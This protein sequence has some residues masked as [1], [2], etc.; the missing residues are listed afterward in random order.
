MW[1]H[2]LFCSRQRE[3]FVKR[4]METN[5]QTQENNQNKIGFIKEKAIIAKYK[6]PSHNSPSLFT[7][8]LT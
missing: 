4:Q 3:N 2:F 8:L 6:N 5:K 1:T 7:N